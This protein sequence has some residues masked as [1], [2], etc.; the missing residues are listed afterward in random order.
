MAVASP[1]RTVPLRLSSVTN[2]NFAAG[3]LAAFSHFAAAAAWASRLES[4]R[5]FWLFATFFGPFATFF[6]VASVA[7]YRRFTFDDQAGPLRIE[8]ALF[9]LRIFRPR[10]VP[11]AD[12]AALTFKLGFDGEDYFGRLRIDLEPKRRYEVYGRPSKLRSQFDRALSIVERSRGA[13]NRPP[14]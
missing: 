3:V 14:M 7:H 4:P 2:W 6:L 1:A 11:L 8:S 9:G 5:M 12:A 13:S 10:A